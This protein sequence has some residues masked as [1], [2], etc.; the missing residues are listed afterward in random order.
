[1]WKLRNF[2]CQC[3]NYLQI[4]LS[5][6]NILRVALQG[7]HCASILSS[8]LYTKA[9]RAIE[10][11]LSHTLYHTVPLYILQQI[12]SPG[13]YIN[14]CT[15]TLYTWYTQLV[16]CER[17]SVCDATLHVS[18]VFRYPGHLLYTLLSYCRSASH[19]L[20]LFSIIRSQGGLKIKNVCHA[21][22][23]VLNFT[24]KMTHL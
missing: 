3:L 21:T 9:F 11:S 6:W 4:K 7:L 12:H 24:C 8:D 14:R 1:M 20:H 18:V 15:A 16:T 2:L 23:F 13:P 10:L 19:T 5:Q 22:L 17:E